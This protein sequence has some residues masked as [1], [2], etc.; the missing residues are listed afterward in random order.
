MVAGFVSDG[1]DVYNISRFDGHRFY[2]VNPIL[3]YLGVGGRWWICMSRA[4]FLLV[5]P[6]A[7]GSN[8]ATL[9]HTVRIVLPP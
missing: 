7:K 9:S 6:L 2:H 8:P 4:F 1:R 5:E 3:F